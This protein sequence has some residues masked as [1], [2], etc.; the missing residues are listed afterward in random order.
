M[1][2]TLHPRH[3]VQL[4]L[5]RGNSHVKNSALSVIEPV[6]Q[7]PTVP[8]VSKAPKK[9]LAT[10]SPAKAKSKTRSAVADSATSY[11]D[12]VD[13]RDSQPVVVKGR[14]TTLLLPHIEKR[15]YLHKGS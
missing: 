6:P 2:G 14:E 3:E 1:A 7:V 11:S 15:T 13:Q 4:S 12:L 8:P 5:L 9:R 10:S